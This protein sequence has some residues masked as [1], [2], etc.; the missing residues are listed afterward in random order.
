MVALP[1]G[2]DFC[3]QPDDNAWLYPCRDF[4]MME[5][6]IDIARIKALDRPETY[7]LEQVSESGWEACEPCSKLV[8]AGKWDEVWTR[9]LDYSV[10][11]GIDRKFLLSHQSVVIE[12]WHTFVLRRNGKKQKL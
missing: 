4:V 11:N 7:T 2:C 6:D 5:H 1:P 10:A 9:L 3:G 12:M 8:D